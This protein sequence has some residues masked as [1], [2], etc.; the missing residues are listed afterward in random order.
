MAFTD[1][2]EAATPRRRQEVRQ[3]GQVARSIELSSAF[4]LTVCVIVLRYSLP[5][6]FMQLKLLCTGTLIHL[7]ES[8]WTIENV[9]RGGIVTFLNVARLSAPILA[10]AVLAGIAVNLAQVGFLLTL[11][12]LKPDFNRLNPIMGF[13]RLFSTRGGVDLMKSVLKVVMVSAVAFA[14]ARSQL[15]L[16]ISTAQMSTPMALS[17]L[18]GILY[19][20]CLRVCVAMLILAAL[21]YIYQRVHFEQSIRMTREEV[22]EEM[23]QMEGDPTLRAR[24]RRRQR[25]IA[26]Q[27]MMQEVPRADVV[28]TNPTRLA[29]ALRYAAGEMSAP[30]VVAKGQ[31]LMAE[32]IREVARQHGVPIVENKPL[33]QALFKSVEIGQEIPAELYQAVAEVLAFVYRLKQKSTVN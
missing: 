3:R 25:E 30:T 5:W 19:T 33:A 18:G 1:R 22:R 21:D 9:H 13:G 26:R 14:T 4:I 17:A 12:P 24:I 15:P 11:E 6:L 32:R 10:A 28:I 8:D 23:R 16:F 2:T 27:R 20:L 29:V 7:P 31:R